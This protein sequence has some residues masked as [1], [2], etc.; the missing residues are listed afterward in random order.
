M[1]RS[2]HR[3]CQWAHG[4]EQGGSGGE[5]CR[6]CQRAAGS[7]RQVP[8][9]HPMWGHSTGSRIWGHG[10]QEGA[11]AWRRAEDPQHRDGRNARA[12]RRETVEE[13]LEWGSV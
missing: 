10:A 6:E 8:V 12:L 13:Q 11:Q 5:V 9:G 1:E 2:Q 7:M 4:L 3:N